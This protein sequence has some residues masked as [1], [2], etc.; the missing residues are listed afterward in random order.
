MSI[1][2]HSSSHDLRSIIF[3]LPKVELHRHLE[4]S[5]RLATLSEIA[6]ENGVDLPTMDPEELRPYVQV[7]EEDDPDFKG[8]LAKFSLLRRFYSSREA[9][10]RVAY[11]AVADAAADN[12]RYLELRF[13]PVALALNQGFSFEDVTDWVIEAVDQASLDHQIEVRLIV[14][15]NRMEPQ[16]APELTEIAVAKQDKGIVGLDLAGDEEAYGDVTGLIKVFQWAKAEGLFVTVHAAEAGPPSNITSAVEKLG[17]ERIG[18]GVQAMRSMEVI[19]LI[20]KKNITLEMCPT[21]NLQ[22]GIVGRLHQHPV[23]A[24]HQLGIP[25][26]INTDDPSICNITLTDEFIVATRGIGM[27]LRILPDIILNAAKAAFLR[28]PEKTRLV[29]WFRKALNETFIIS[30]LE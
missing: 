7:V 6:Y 12:I 3:N 11:E 26:T 8:F 19:D 24:Y 25:V 20:R 15:I 29:N 22:T 28:E 18:H 21:S 4:G 9:V 13:N 23:Y 10:M 30:S 17:A 16:Y 5:L 27:P 14:L 2:N 1:N